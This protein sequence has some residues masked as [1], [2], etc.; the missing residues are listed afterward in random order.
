MKQLKEKFIQK[1][2]KKS[3][4]VDKSIVWVRLKL[5]T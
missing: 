1:F 2:S 5:S 3:L 4:V